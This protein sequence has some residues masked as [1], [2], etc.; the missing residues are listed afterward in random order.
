MDEGERE[1][2]QKALNEACRHR[3]AD[4]KGDDVVENAKKYF[5]FLQGE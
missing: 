1:N 4:E 5:A 2:R 3:L